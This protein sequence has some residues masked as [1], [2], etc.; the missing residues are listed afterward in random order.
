MTDAEINSIIIATERA[1]LPKM[2]E[3]RRKMGDV[4]NSVDQA[5]LVSEWL[6]NYFKKQNKSLRLKDRKQIIEIYLKK[7]PIFMDYPFLPWKEVFAE[8]EAFPGLTDVEIDGIIIDAERANLPKMIEEQKK[9]RNVKN[10]VDQARLISEWLT[11]YFKKQNKSLSL[12]D[13]TKIITTFIERHPLWILT[14]TPWDEVF[15]G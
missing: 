4:K 9:I 11:N 8:K 12:M 6:T 14:T 1:N 3:G 15:Y 7:H 10:Q 2:I 5:R 13:R